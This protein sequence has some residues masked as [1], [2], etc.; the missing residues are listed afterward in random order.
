MQTATRVT[1]C[2]DDV[3]E[4][5]PDVDGGLSADLDGVPVVVGSR[6]DNGSGGE[7]GGRVV[8]GEDDDEPTQT[9][10]PRDVGG[11][12]NGLAGGNIANLKKKHIITPEKTRQ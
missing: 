11:D 4:Q 8:D 9:S 12:Y 5:C 2:N 7:G 3:P 10:T 6:D 1:M